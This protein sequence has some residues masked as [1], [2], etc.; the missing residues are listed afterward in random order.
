MATPASGTI[1][2]LNMRTEI[3]RGTGAISMS[4]VRNRYG[5]AGAISFSELYDCEGYVYT[6]GSYRSKFLNHDGWLVGVI[7]SVTPAESNSRVQIAAASFIKSAYSGVNA[8][9]T[10]VHISQN[11]SV[12]GLVSGNGDQVTV[13]YRATDVTRYVQ[14]NTVRTI[15][16]V[17]S[18][19]TASY[20]I[21]SGWSGNLQSSPQHCLIKF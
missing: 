8:A 19:T 2:M 7:G 4:E 12:A 17:V 15:Q 18:N 9:N 5:S 13:G 1:S 16:V 3:T 14:A 20:I 11:N 21:V 10:I 6:P